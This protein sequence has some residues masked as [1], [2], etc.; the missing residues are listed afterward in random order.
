MAFEFWA[1][2]ISLLQDNRPSG[3]QSASDHPDLDYR[4]PQP[5]VYSTGD[6]GG[7]LSRAEAIRKKDEALLAELG[8]KQE[9]K[10]AFTPLEVRHP[11]RDLSFIMYWLELSLISPHLC[12]RRSLE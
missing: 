8:Y 1:I 11:L 6:L 12:G 7:E 9:F 2:Y 5:M 3:E 4:L 10:R